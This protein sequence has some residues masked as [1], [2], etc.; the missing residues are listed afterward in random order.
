[1]ANHPGCHGYER[2]R[3]HINHEDL[4][5]PRSFKKDTE[6][7]LYEA[8]KSASVRRSWEK[9]SGSFQYFSISVQGIPLFPYLWRQLLTFLMWNTW[10]LQATMKDFLPNL[11]NC[12]P[13]L[14]NV[15]VCNRSSIKQVF[16]LVEDQISLKMTVLRCF[17]WLFPVV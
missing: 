12:F 7:L 11:I 1:M 16:W 15:D 9:T 8:D 5:F 6:P 13:L 4:D 3:K 14:M 10:I 2:V 17:L